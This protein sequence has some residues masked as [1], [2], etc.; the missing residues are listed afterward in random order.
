PF[1]VTP[2]EH[3]IVSTKVE[4]VT[5]GPVTQEA[6]TKT[7]GD[8]WYAARQLRSAFTAERKTEPVE[9]EAALRTALERTDVDVV[10]TT[11]TRADNLAANAALAGA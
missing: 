6:L 10:M 11:T 5:S 2:E 9:A 4:R 7:G 8:V 3:E 1:V